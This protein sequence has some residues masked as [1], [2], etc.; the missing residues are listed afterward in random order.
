MTAVQLGHS[1][2]PEEFLSLIGHLSDSSHISDTIFLVK[3][4]VAKGER[5]VFKAVTAGRGA[6]WLRV[7]RGTG[8]VS[9]AKLSSV[10][11][12]R[13]RVPQPCHTFRERVGETC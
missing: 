4:R 12:E 13:L 10:S 5:A 9:T 2:K 6:P 1:V 7:H 3:C 11:P 8:Q